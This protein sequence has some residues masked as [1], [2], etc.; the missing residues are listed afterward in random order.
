MRFRQ[1]LKKIVD[2]KEEMGR[3]MKASFFSLAQVGEWGWGA[4]VWCGGFGR[5]D[6]RRAVKRSSGRQGSAGL[7]PPAARWVAAACW[8][9]AAV[10]P[11]DRGVQGS[12][13]FGPCDFPLQAKYASGDFKHTVFDSVDQVCFAIL[14]FWADSVAK[15][16]VPASCWCSRHV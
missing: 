2:T 15:P 7:F 9:Q 6:W 3:V 14:Q 8:P 10:L 5:I 12:Q 11:C 4:A 16:C 13:E 1:I